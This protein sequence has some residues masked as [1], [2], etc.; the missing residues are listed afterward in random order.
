MKTLAC[1]VLKAL[2][3]KTLATAESCTGGGIGQA[4][5]EVSGS[6]RVYKGGVVS[7]W[8]SIKQELLHV[9]ADV[10]EAQGPV[11][12][13]VACQMA[14]GARELLKADVSVSVT[15]LAG[16][17]G[18]EYGNPQGL[19]YIGYADECRCFAREYHFSGSRSRVRKAAVKKALET[20]LEMQ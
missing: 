7:Y 19:V 12:P 20:I 4:L 11:C 17:G 5:T 13:E 1:K 6:S 9:G 16:P 15:G 8:S 14:R 10:L 18:D 2:D 3:G